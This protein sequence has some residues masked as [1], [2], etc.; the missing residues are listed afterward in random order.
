MRWRP[1]LALLSSSTTASSSSAMRSTVGSI[2]SQASSAVIGAGR[3][4]KKAMAG[5]SISRMVAMSKLPGFM[6]LAM[7]KIGPRSGW[8]ST[9]RWNTFMWPNTRP[10]FS[11]ATTM[12][13]P[14]SISPARAATNKDTILSKSWLAR[15]PRSLAGLAST[16][17]RPSSAWVTP[18]SSVKPAPAA[19]A[20][21]S[22]SSGSRRWPAAPS[23]PSTRRPCDFL[24]GRPNRKI[25]AISSRPAA[26]MPMRSIAMSDIRGVS[27]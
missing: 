22:P 27:G 23:A 13:S 8:P 20:S 6:M 12:S 14:R 19:P 18:F 15:L 26:R 4:R 1:R 10:V 2:F 7:E 9:S 24:R 17:G 11:A 16:S 5:V 25:A 3:V 21:C